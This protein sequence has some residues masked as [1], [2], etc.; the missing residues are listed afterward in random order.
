VFNAS[1][2]LPLNA[3]RKYKDM[4]HWLEGHWAIH[5]AQHRHSDRLQLAT[6]RRTSSSIP[7]NKLTCRNNNSLPFA[8]ERIRAHGLCPATLPS[9]V[10][11]PLNNKITSVYIYIYI[12]IYIHVRHNNNKIHNSKC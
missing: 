2:P 11:P 4:C 8:S 1:Y 6:P 5:C 12:Y 9:T 10:C 3:Q 7:I